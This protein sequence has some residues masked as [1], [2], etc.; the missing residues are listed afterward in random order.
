MTVIILIYSFTHLHF[1]GRSVLT[2]EIMLPDSLERS[3]KLFNAESI[4]DRVHCRVA[5][6]E[7]DGDVDEQDGVLTRGAEERDAVQDMKR[8][9][10]DSKQKEDKSERLCQFQFFVVVLVRVGVARAHLL[11]QLL[12]N[13]VEDL[14]VDAK[15]EEKWRQHPAEKIEVNHIF[16]TDDILKLAGD[17][18]VTAKRAILLLEVA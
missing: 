11:V 9:P 8:K 14:C 5:V 10:T 12:V 2:A 7:Q 1:D 4:D 17:D 16:H 18:D 6:S 13:H 15:H 3:A